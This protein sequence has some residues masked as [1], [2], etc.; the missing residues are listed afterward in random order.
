MQKYRAFLLPLAFLLTSI[1]I[2]SAQ[3]APSSPVQP[4]QPTHSLFGKEPVPL[5]R[6]EAELDGDTVYTLGQLIDFAEDNNPS[7]HAAWATARAA[8]SSLG[9][10][11]S[12][13]YPTVIALAGGRTFL[14]PPLLYSS[15]YLQ[16]IGAFETALNL[17]YTL[18]DFG[19]RRDEINAAK[20]RLLAANL[21]F[22]NEHLVLIQKVSAAYYRLLNAIGLRKAAE[23]TLND[24][25]T[26][27]NAVR[28]RKANGL[29]TL[30]D[31]L[32][33]EAARAKA[34]Y[35][36]QSM[37]GNE[38]TAFGDLATVLTASPVKPFKVQEL[39]NISIPD[40]LDHS[41]EDEIE[42]A[43]QTRPDLLANIEQVKASDAEI[44]LA[45]SAYFPKLTFDG[46]KGWLRAWGKQEK[47]NGTY[48]KTFTYDAKL[49]LTWT[50]FD[51][52]KRENRLSRAKAEHDAAI[53]E[54]REKEDAIAD[55]VWADYANAQTALDQK[56][57]AAS[58]LNASNESYSAA[59]ESYRDGVRN[60]LDVLSAER[61]LANARAID[62]TARTQV[63][64]SFMNLAFRTGALLSEHPKGN[65]P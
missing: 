57:A 64:Q 35:E 1:P 29:A 20:A 14:N 22:N 26:V 63:L 27:E 11:R 33:A 65:H 38:K 54:V 62:V 30:P 12:E 15:F 24:A 13:L 60:I 41:V 55:H 61:D 4:W 32:E 28:D 46:S 58:L 7:T 36:L 6:H 56:K 9:I 10:A 51:G 48:G 19:A 52:F 34:E 17:D 53:E 59:V 21:N 49:S 47:N 5:Y 42:A 44:K 50:V 2:A 8:A 18:V 43:Y 25:R 31:L 40:A 16:D 3:K 23:V 37:I 45:R 39:S